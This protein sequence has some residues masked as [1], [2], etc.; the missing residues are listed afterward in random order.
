M[1]RSRLALRHPREE[2]A[3][4]ARKLAGSHYSEEASQQNPDPLN[5]ISTYFQ[6][7]VP[8]LIAQN[9]RVMLSVFDQSQ[10]PAVRA[11]RTAPTKAVA[12]EFT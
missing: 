6:V 10:K 9:P 4:M 2:R 7:V 11:M 3:R 8:H 12:K 1:K 5:L